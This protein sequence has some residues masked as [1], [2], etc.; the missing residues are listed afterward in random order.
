VELGLTFSIV[1]RS[2]EIASEMS[3]PLLQICVDANIMTPLL[4]WSSE[5]MLL[6]NKEKKRREEKEKR[7]EGKGREEREEKRREEKRR[8]EKRREEK[9]RKRKR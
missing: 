1:L 2:F 6:L 4:A 9:R 8:E 3:C 5:R 7:R